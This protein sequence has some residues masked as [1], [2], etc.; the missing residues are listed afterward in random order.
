MSNKG[1]TYNNRG[2]ER[3]ES[4]IV[5]R[6]FREVSEILNEED[7]DFPVK[8]ISGVKQMMI[9]AFYKIALNVASELLQL[10]KKHELVKE[11]AEYLSTQEFFHEMVVEQMVG[12]DIAYEDITEFIE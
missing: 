1:K 6:T 8:T 2:I 7:P 10:P 12:G 11:R 5:A 9:R 3:G 4:T